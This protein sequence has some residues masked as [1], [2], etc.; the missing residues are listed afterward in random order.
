MSSIKKVIY[1]ASLAAAL[2]ACLSQPVLAFS[3]SDVQ[4]LVD[5]VGKEAVTGNVLVW[6]LCAVAFL[7]ISQKVDSF[8]S[9]LGINVGHTGGSLLAEAMI[10]VRGIG[11]AG[12]F[13]GQ[14]FRG[15]HSMDGNA[16]SGGFLSG[17]LAGVVSRKVAGSAV[18]TATAPLAPRHPAG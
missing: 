13:Y 3:E 4:A 9:G 15:A 14:R 16:G 17:G 1:T 10:A 11:I 6:F 2:S 5:A 7:K 12:V 8:M 18:K